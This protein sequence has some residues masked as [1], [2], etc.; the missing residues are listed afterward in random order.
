METFAHR[1]IGLMSL[2][3]LLVS[4][5][6]VQAAVRQ[7]TPGTP[8]LASL[9]NALNADGTLKAGVSGSLDPRGWRMTTGPHGEPRFMRT[10]T[11]GAAQSSASSIATAPVAADVNWDDRFGAPG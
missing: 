1:V 10:S 11:S 9:G 8:A 7:E 4:S 6:T 5:V 3:I 2:F